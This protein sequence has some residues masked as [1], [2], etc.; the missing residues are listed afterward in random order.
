[1]ARWALIDILSCYMCPRGTGKFKADLENRNGEATVGP[2]SEMQWSVFDF[3][4]KQVLDY[5]T[6]RPTPYFMKT[7]VPFFTQYAQVS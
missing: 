6:F 5:D 1:M 3:A 7:Q 4:T 2:S